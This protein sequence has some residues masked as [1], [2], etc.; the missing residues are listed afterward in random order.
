MTAL[1]RLGHGSNERDGGELPSMYVRLFTDITSCFE[2]NWYEIMKV[3][4]VG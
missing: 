4:L 2:K 3:D 1:V